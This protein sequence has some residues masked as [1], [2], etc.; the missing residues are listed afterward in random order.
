MSDI[1]LPDWFADRLPVISSTVLVTGLLLDVR[2][3]RRRRR[4]RRRRAG[5]GRPAHHDDRARGVAHDVIRDAPEE[6]AP[7]AATPVAAEDD[8]IDPLGPRGVDDRLAGV[9]LP[10]EELGRDADVVAACDED[11][12]RG[13]AL[14]ADLVDAGRVPSA[15]QPQR[16]R[17]D[18]ADR[19]QAGV[20]GGPR[21]GAPPPR[22]VRTSA[23]GPSRAAR[24]R[25]VASVP[26]ASP[27]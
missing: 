16:A 18:D 19:E 6:G 12:G 1:F 5:S 20:R 17:V 24:P 8:E 9:A 2:A 27:A 26:V 3:M 10:D 15:G 23:R 13:L 25:T 14:V 7:D 11:L 21:A 4:S 22:R